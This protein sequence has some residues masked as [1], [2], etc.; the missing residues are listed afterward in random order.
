MDTESR[1]ETS[2]ARRSGQA[3]GPLD[4]EGRGKPV[5]RRGGGGGETLPINHGRLPY[6]LLNVESS[7]CTAVVTI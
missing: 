5:R 1:A 3:H 2:W 6:V 4:L 7:L